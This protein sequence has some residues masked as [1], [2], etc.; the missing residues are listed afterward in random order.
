MD[1]KEALKNLGLNE[2]EAKVYITLLEIGQTTAYKIA[3][4][5][6][7]KRPTVYVVLDELRMKGLV[8]K[9]PHA[10]KQLFT[11]KGSE[12]F[13]REAEERLQTAKSILPQILAIT[14]GEKKPKTLYF[15][16]MS[17]VQEILNYGLEKMA[18]KEF[19]GFY[20]HWKEDVPKEVFEI[21]EKYNGKLKQM[22][23]GIRGV[24]PE[25]PS[26]EYYRERDKEYGRNIKTV[27][28]NIYSA[29]ISI[30]IGTDFI[31]LIDPTTLQGVVIENKSIAETMR[32]IFEMV[33]NNS[34]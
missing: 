10:K 12:E 13:F 31:R 15:E 33:W 19:A 3:E 16:G 8:L 23:I 5:S 20:A 34:A 7:L 27:P 21:A 22:K 28:Y 2:K 11:A 17:G 9:I 32:Q 25:H 14:A 6:G 4:K 1:I 26:L 29:P 30:D 24:A 18:G